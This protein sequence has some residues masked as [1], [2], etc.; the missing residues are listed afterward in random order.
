[1]ADDESDQYTD[2][3][4]K[5]ISVKENLP[6]KLS[7]AEEIFAEIDDELPAVVEYGQEITENLA[8][9]IMT[10]FHEKWRHGDIKKTVMQRQKLPVNCKEICTPKLQESILSIKSISDHQKRSERGL[11]NTQ[12]VVIK[13]TAAITNILKDVLSAEAESKMVDVKSI[14]R[15]SLDAVT[16]LGSISH[17]ISVKRKQNIR[18]SLN[19]QYQPLCNANRPTTQFLLGDDLQKGMKEAQESSRLGITYSAKY[20][21]TYSSNKGSSSSS[22]GKTLPSPHQKGSKSFLDKGKRPSGRHK[23]HSSSRR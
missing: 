9:R 13:A 6:P 14:I 15:N 4:Q 20:P 18:N 21:K 12:N 7:V 3:L 1:M 5:K 22:S 23:H 10:H 2:L 11:Y 17:D 19:Y 8:S 16:L